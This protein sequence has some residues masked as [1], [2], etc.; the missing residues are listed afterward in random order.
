MFFSSEDLRSCCGLPSTFLVRTY[1]LRFSAAPSAVASL[2][3]FL[4]V[5]SGW[6]SEYVLNHWPPPSPLR[7]LSPT[8][9]TYLNTQPTPQGQPVSHIRQLF[10]TKVKDILQCKCELRS[11]VESPLHLSCVMEEAVYLVK[12]KTNSGFRPFN[13]SKSIGITLP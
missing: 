11:G 10:D 9:F 8:L 7:H 2:L 12:S 4:V 6:I 1:H 3:F 13:S 5:G